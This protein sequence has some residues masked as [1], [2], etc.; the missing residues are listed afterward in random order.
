M[1]F[2]ATHQAPAKPLLG[3][4]CKDCRTVTHLSDLNDAMLCE[5][6][7]EP[8]QDPQDFSPSEAYLRKWEGTYSI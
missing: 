4:R 3:Y 8:D 2:D 5:A 1:A 6:C 7:G